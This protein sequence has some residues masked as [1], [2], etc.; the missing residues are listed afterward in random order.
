VK[1]IIIKTQKE[2]DAA[3]D[4]SE[5]TFYIEGGTQFSP[6]ELTTDFKEAY[7][8]VRGQA[9]V[10]LRESSHAELRESS[11]AELRGSSHAVLR[12]SS[13]AELWESSHAELRGSSH[14]VLRE[15]S[16]AVL[17]ESS[18]AVLWE[19]SH[20]ELRGSSHAVLRESSHAVLWESSHAELRESSHAVLWESSHA[21][22]WGE[23]LVSAFSAKEIVAHGYNV[24]SL[25][26]SAKKTI[27]L[28]VGK[29]A[30]LKIV[31]DFKP[32]FKEFALRYPVEVKGKNAIMYKAVH[33]RD[34]KY[35]SDYSSGF[36]Y[37]IGKE[38][39]HDCAPSSDG[40][41][42][43][44]L[45]VSHKSWARGFGGGWIDFALL[46]CEVPI[47]SIVVSKDTD[48]KVRTSKLTV[49][50]EVPASEYWQ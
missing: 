26:K 42:A 47:K 11:H 33:K 14:A 8:I 38:K 30:T 48:G 37:E 44:G 49:L 43:P 22:L 6:L 20:A 7:V 10:R 45:H 34:G 15:S 12:E 50:R 35:F 29:N 18:H 27:K 13:H 1:E 4:S 16:H 19:S 5:T 46:E 9:W 17:W 23:A 31:P 39:T 24:I 3:K 32:T 2:L 36:E 40:S 25:R 21:V 41:C 28:V